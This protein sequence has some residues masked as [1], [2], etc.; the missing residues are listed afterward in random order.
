MTSTLQIFNYS[1]ASIK[2]DIIDIAYGSGYT[3]GTDSTPTEKTGQTV[4]AI[5]DADSTGTGITMPAGANAG[6]LQFYNKSGNLSNLILDLVPSSDSSKYWTPIYI[7]CNPTIS[8][9]GSTTTSINS[10]I[11]SADTTQTG[12]YLIVGEEYM[13]ASDFDFPSSYMALGLPTVTSSDMSDMKQVTDF[14]SGWGMWTWIGIGVAILLLI[15]LVVGGVVF[16]K[17]RSS[18]KKAQETEVYY[19]DD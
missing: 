1:G 17:K 15:L 10:Q 11:Y 8:Y 9:T 18:K 3:S 14:S 19:D 4:A 2:F 5:T 13:N 7:M 12:N 16:M 6:S